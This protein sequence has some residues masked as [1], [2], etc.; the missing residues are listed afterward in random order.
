MADNTLKLTME[1]AEGGKVLSTVTLEYPNIPNTEA[2][3][4]SL[5]IIE[6]IGLVVRG[7]AAFKAQATG[8]PPEIVEAIR[9]KGRSK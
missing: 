9:G 5:E 1:Q 8:S 4:L 6:A 2:N 7:A 3:M